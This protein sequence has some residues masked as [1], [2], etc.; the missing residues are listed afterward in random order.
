MSPQ[1][2]ALTIKDIQRETPEA[3]SIAFEVPDALKDEYQFT[4]G[5]YLTLRSI[6]DGEDIRRSYSICSAVREELRVAV[7]T[8]DGGLFSTFAN[9][10]LSP[11]MAL[12]V[13][14]PMGRFQL[15]DEAQPDSKTESEGE[16]GSP[17]MSNYVGFAAGSG[18]TPILSMIKTVLET[19]LN[20]RFFLFY[21]NRTA[22]S[23]LFKS[24]LE[25]LKDRFLGRLSV[26][27]VLSGEEQDLPI[28]SGRLDREKIGAFLS[29]VIP[30]ERIDHA[31]LCGPGSM[32]DTARAALTEAGLE[33]S[34]IHMELFT[35]ADGAKTRKQAPQATG[36]VSEN[37]SSEAIVDLILDG[38]RQTVSLK[39]GETIIEGAIR[40]GLEAPYSCKGGMCCTCRAKLVDG[41]AHMAV[42]YSLEPWEIEAG[43]VLACQTRPV[44]GRILVDFDDA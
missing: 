24:A 4:P 10:D 19:R 15:P 6:I 11:G 29:S 13:M 28:L 40:Q 31:F 20:S 5:Q 26:Y 42:N 38:V 36:S 17:H 3:V 7:K 32:T 39:P 2:H 21:G 44:S 18:I 27:H 23:I 9:R 37:A 41:D 22:Q 16:T 33:D 30:A 35:P 12:Q 1:F 14:T 8:V 34:R 25:D 43:Y